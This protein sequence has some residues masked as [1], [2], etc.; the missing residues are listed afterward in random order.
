MK[1]SIILSLLMLFS[2]TIFTQQ[3]N[4]CED[5]ELLNPGDPIAQTSPSWNSWD[6]LMNG[7]TAPFIDDALISSFQ[8]YSGTNSLHIPPTQNIP[9]LFLPYPISNLLV[10]FRYPILAF[11]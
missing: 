3:I 4:F 6:E 2:T 5:F 11:I 7:S 1:K 10:P 8:S 9:A